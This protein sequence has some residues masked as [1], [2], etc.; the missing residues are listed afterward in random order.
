M[1]SSQGAERYTLFLNPYPDHRFTRCPRCREKTSDRNRVLVVQLGPGLVMPAMVTCRYCAGCDLLIAHQDEVSA[2]LRQMLPPEE[3]GALGEEMAVIGTLDRGR[4]RGGGL[5]DVTPQEAMEAFCPIRELVH[6]DLVQDKT[7]SIETVEKTVPQT[8]TVT[9]VP[10]PALAEVQAL[11]QPEETWQIAALRMWTWI[12]GE[13]VGPYRPY[14]VLIVGPAGPFVVFQEMLKNEPSPAQVRD[15][16][17]KAMIRPAMG[18][19]GPRRPMAL[20]MEDET[21]ADALQPELDALNIHC[22]TGPT[23]E[24][25]DVLADLEYFLAGGHEPHP[26][27]LDDP[28]VTPEQV[29]ELFEAAA[30]FYYEAPWDLMLDED[31]VALRY[32]V[33]GGEWRFVS[34]MGNAGMEFGLAVFEDLFDYDLLATTPPEDMVGMMDYRSLTY[35]DVTAMPF[36]DLDALEYYDWEVAADDAYPIPVTFTA[37][38]EI[39]RPGPEEIEWYTVALRAVEAFFQDY[40]PDEIDYVPEPVSTTLTVSLTGRRVKVELRY[41][42]DLVVDEELNA[43]DG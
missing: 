39:L 4:L 13:E 5:E 29:G 10:V 2:V 3:R 9:E 23:P 36:P 17:L 18:T 35:D 30:D 6:F 41:P 31:L 43:T 16:L 7:G 27:L 21:L 12:T 42:A 40:W 20:V 37:D 28:R 14:L 25:D 8:Q 1:D 11:P 19:G 33:P 38:E 34:V 24:L 26:G 32:P 22:A 15:M